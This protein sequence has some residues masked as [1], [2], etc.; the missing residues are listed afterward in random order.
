M[1]RAV[2]LD[3]YG[4]I[5]E[6]SYGLLARVA[7]EFIAHGARADR[8]KIEQ[9]WWDEFRA[10]CD[11]SNGENFRTQKQIY[12]LAFSAM[13][14]KTGAE[15]LD[16][17]RLR[18][19]VVRFSAAS[20][21][22]GD[23]RRFFEACRLPVYILSNIDSAEI[24]RLI[25]KHRLPVS[26][27]F[28]SEDAREYKPRRGIFEKGLAHFGLRADE[29]VYAGDSL[30]NDYYGARNAGILS[31]W[32]NRG[33]APVPEGVRALPDLYALIGA[34]GGTEG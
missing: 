7:E 5:V 21:V 33:N 25:A 2:M 19:E 16:V 28:T 8:Q 4:T 14:E 1:I 29:T 17:L 30:A 23:A 34:V 13:A 10:L 24:G 32:L 9:M 27:V 20:P 11:A 26:G 31:Y 15:G 22:F 12:P 18:D 6:E 3:C